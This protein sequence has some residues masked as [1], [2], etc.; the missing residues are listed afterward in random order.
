M[1]Y[2]TIIW[3]SWFVFEIVIARVKKS[4]A[5]NNDI[6]KKSFNI[7]WLAIMFGISLAVLLQY[8]VNLPFAKN[9][10]IPY[11]G[12]A[13]IILGVGIRIIAIISLG[14]SFTVD[15]NVSKEQKIKQ[16]GLYKYVRH[17]AYTGSLLS[18]LGL[19]LSFNNIL[20]FFTLIIVV[21]WAFL[22]R[23]KI[24][25]KALTD[26]FGAEYEEYI[27]KTKKLLPFIV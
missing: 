19:G 5:K 6:D 21:F 23:I 27:K 4:K 16:N 20:S 7:L 15:V 13:L 24:E 3:I 26:F 18:F 10:I 11:I 1:K 8:S 12:L 22:Y 25:E 14:K 17:P 2:F 9:M